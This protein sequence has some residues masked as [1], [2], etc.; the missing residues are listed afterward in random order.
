MT[1]GDFSASRDPEDPAFRCTQGFIPIHP[2]RFSL[3]PYDNILDPA[4]PASITEPGDYILRAIRQGYVY[5]FI[6]TPEVSQ[7]ATD[8]DGTWYNFRYM[9]E[10]QDVNSCA[11]PARVQADAQSFG[12]FHKY[13]WTDNYGRGE[14]RY[15]DAPYSHCW[16]PDW[17]SK[18]WVAYSEFAWPP[19]FFE[20]SHDAAFRQQIMMPVVLRG[21]NQW[22]A[23]I[24][25]ALSLVEE[26]KNPED[27]DHLVRVR[28][29]QSQ[30]GFQSRH[31]WR[32]EVTEENA[33]C[34][35]IVAVHDPVG[36][37]AEMYFRSEMIRDE[38]EKLS[39]TFAYPLTIGQ[40]CQSIKGNVPARDGFLNR[41][42]P[43]FMINQPAL[44][45]TWESHYL[46]HKSMV[47][48]RL[49]FLDEL[50][51]SI[52][53]R[54][55]DES[56]QMLGKLLALAT[57]LAE[58]TDDPDG[59]IAEYMMRLLSQP[60]L[61]L[62][63]TQRGI[64]IMRLGLGAT[65]IQS[66]GLPGIQK[67][68]ARMRNVWGAVQKLPFQ[69]MREAQY[70]FHITFEALA[71]PLGMQIAA[72]T[73]S[74]EIWQGALNAGFQSIEGDP[75]LIGSTRK[76]LGE[77]IEFLQRNHET[78]NPDRTYSA[79]PMDIVMDKVDGT[80]SLSVGRVIG[81]GDT[82]DVPYVR[83]ISS[84]T[85]AGGTGAESTI[86]RVE[87]GYQLLGA[88]LSVWGLYSA[89]LSFKRSPTLFANDGF[90]AMGLSY[91]FQLTT[92]SIS[93]M[94][95]VHDT[96]KLLARSR[97]TGAQTIARLS[98][99]AVDTLY[100]GLRLPGN[101][102]TN[103]ANPSMFRAAMRGDLSDAATI[104]GRRLKKHA[105]PLVGYVLGAVTS[106][107]NIG[108]GLARSDKNEV[109]GNVMMLFGGLMMFPGAGWLV[110]TI[111]AVIL[112]VGFLIT[113]T[114][115]DAVEDIA[116]VSFWGTH[117]EYWEGERPLTKAQQIE[118][119]RGLNGPYEQFF[120]DEV[121]LFGELTWAPQISNPTDGDGEI[122]VRTGA[123]LVHGPEAVTVR[124]TRELPAPV[125]YR[126][127]S[128]STT[129]HAIPGTDGVRVSIP[130]TRAGGAWRR[131]KVTA[132]VRGPASGYEPPAAEAVFED[133]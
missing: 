90:T 115:Y 94:I 8:S 113:L 97:Q 22:A 117:D 112:V 44:D 107:V 101:H 21:Q 127:V 88:M 10:T 51:D 124:V 83:T 12:K 39:A 86:Q 19:E 125:G 53:G 84:V 96:Y 20:K 128:V 130:T 87:M 57:Q 103:L 50:A 82:A 25:D 28:L 34:V 116:R 75:I 122:L 74:V 121:A 92:A 73:Q 106:T 9:T 38:H 132:S 102:A 4:K 109:I 6:E 56:D 91:G 18:I 42:L 114:S 16:V 71:I 61:G 89:A 27:I 23:Y 13:E 2:V 66:P 31:D 46:A 62:A 41:N 17:A 104:L 24:G 80:T 33:D 123:I 108:R 5:I 60:L 85:L 99:D 37:V 7:G 110:A 133:P 76:S 54:M 36:D 78:N 63:C 79:S 95:S 64:D 58:E 3:Q 81:T 65:D 93:V 30:T 49:T 131:V 40:F 111:G 14:W 68:L 32:P 43:E 77:A 52:A 45:P 118:M 105:I 98:S 1:I 119:S 29:A 67:W 26:F 69:R 15:D 47:E 59:H 70:S 48:A 72:G 55:N 120:R 35:A 100:K 129:R 11:N 126:T